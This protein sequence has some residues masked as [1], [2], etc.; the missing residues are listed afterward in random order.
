MAKLALTLLIAMSA[1]VAVQAQFILT[2]YPNMGSFYSHVR[3][4]NNFMNPWFMSNTYPFYNNYYANPW[5][6]PNYRFMVK[7]QMPASGP[8]PATDNFMMGETDD[9]DD[10]NNDDEDSDK[11][12]DEADKD[13]EKRE[14]GANPEPII[15]FSFTHNGLFGSK[16]ISFGW[17]APVAVDPYPS[18]HPVSPY[19]FFDW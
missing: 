13:V 6:W 5:L 12:T 2:F 15:P 14:A 10:G 3:R 1:L 4:N 17:G 16:H 8:F 18:Y 19:Q 7:S 9:S 11:T